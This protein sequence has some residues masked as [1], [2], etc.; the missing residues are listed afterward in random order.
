M[1]YT[2]LD[3]VTRVLSEL[4]SD[5]VDSIEDTI[6]AKE[7]ASIVRDVYQSVTTEYSWLANENFINPITS[8]ES[9]IEL[10][11]NI[12][13]IKRVL[14]KPSTICGDTVSCQAGRIQN[15]VYTKGG[16]VTANCNTDAKGWKE[17]TYLDKGDFMSIMSTTPYDDSN[18]IPYAHYGVYTGTQA[19]PTYYT[20]IYNHLI[21][22]SICKEAYENFPLSDLRLLGQ[23]TADIPLEDGAVINLNPQLFAYFLAECKS[24]AFFSIKQMPN[25]K[26]EQLAQR[27]RR[28]LV[29]SKSRQGRNNTKIKYPNKSSWR[30]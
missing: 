30:W 17:L 23:Y 9:I 12:T 5:M 29:N 2:M 25:T 13:H 3:T 28:Q 10:Q 18:G 20:V 24:Q 11:P 19:N 4:N 14:I 22:D 8:D 21:L 16:P 15:P 26:I 6:E 27:L 7:I 1:A